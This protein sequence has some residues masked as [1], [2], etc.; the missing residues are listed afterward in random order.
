MKP[1]NY[2]NLK[3]VTTGTNVKLLF[4]HSIRPSLKGVSDTLS[5]SLTEEGCNIAYEFGKSL[6]WSIGVVSTSLANRCIQTVKQIIKDSCSDK[7]IKSTEI[8]TSPTLFDLELATQTHC[9]EG[10][11]KNIAHKL[12]MRQNLPGFNSM[13]ITA[14]KLLDYIFSVGNEYDKLDLF[15]THD[16]NIILLLLYLVPNIKSKDVIVENWPDPLEG[17]FIWGKRYDFYFS[18]KGNIYHHKY[19][20]DKTSQFN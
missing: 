15:C 2:D 4:R 14:E 1:I 3:I 13:N 20:D 8:L 9:A 19:S 18:W 6:P 7:E 11:L 5:I 10:S 12:S 16:F 17:I